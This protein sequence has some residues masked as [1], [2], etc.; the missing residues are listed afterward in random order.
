[1]A[2]LNLEQRGFLGGVCN[3]CRKKQVRES[4]EVKSVES[5]EGGWKV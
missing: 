1:M 4:W 2:I 3:N 5:S